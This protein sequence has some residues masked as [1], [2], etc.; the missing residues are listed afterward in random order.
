MTN[1]RPSTAKKMTRPRWAVLGE[2]LLEGVRSW[3]VEREYESIEQLKGSLS[4]ENCPDPSAYERANYM[5]TLIS[6]S[7]GYTP[8]G[9]R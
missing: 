2:K 9:V 4:Q 3:M 8:G 6:Y 1:D 7:G 5:R